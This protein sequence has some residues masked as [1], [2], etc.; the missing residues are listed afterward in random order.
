MTT[1]RRVLFQFQLD[2]QD[3]RALR[4]HALERDLTASALVRG[5]VMRLLRDLE[6][7]QRA[8]RDDGETSR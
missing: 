3:R 5:A 8:P 2:A 6:R 1:R 7:G 4:R